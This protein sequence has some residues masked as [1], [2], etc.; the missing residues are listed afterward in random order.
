M[1]RTAYSHLLSPGRIGTLELRNR[2][3]VAAMG[4]NFGELDGASSELLVAYHE[5]QARGGVGL[6][7]SGACGVMYPVGKVQPWQI[8]ISEDRFIPGLKKVVDAVHR[9]GAKFAVQ[10]HMGGLVAGDD[11]REGRPQWC[12][13]VPEPMKGDFID[14]FLLDEL[15]SF[16]GAGVPTYKVLEH[17][18][19]QVVVKAY[20]AG[21]RRAKQA[22]CDAVEIHGGHGYLLSSFLSPKTNKR[23]DEYGGSVENRS[24]FLLEVVRAVRA[25]VGADFAVWVKLD[26]REVGKEGGITLEHATATARLVEEAGADGIAVSAYHDTGQ[27]KLHSGSNIPHEPNTN[28]PAAAAIKA[29]V[30]ISVIAAGRVEPE[31]ADAEIRAGKFDF[32]AMG[33]KLLADPQLPNKLAAGKV[34]EVR[35]CIY[36]YTCVSAIYTRERMR[37]AVNTELGIEYLRVNAPRPSVRKRVVV[38]GGGPGGMEA[39]RRLAR[40]GHEVVLLE[41]SER[42]GGTLR[43]AALAYAANERLLDWLRL[44]IET[45]DVDLRLNT[46]ATPEL[47][48]SLHPDEVVVATGARRNMPPIPGSELPH[49]FSGD[50]MRGMMLGDS[51]PALQQKTSLL[52][53][54]ATKAGA[55]TGLTA[56]LDFVRKA[57]HAWMPLGK[58]V[59]IIGGELVGL[60]LAEFLVERGRSVTIIDEAPRFGAGMTLVRRLRLLAELREHGLGLYPGS[61]DIRIATGKVAFV[62]SAGTAHSVAAEHV[63]VAKGATGDSTQADAFR[64]AG[65][66]VHEVGDGSGVGYIEGAMRGALRAVDAINAGEAVTGP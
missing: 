22:G 5:E 26:S 13:S 29:A 41:K 3:V 8:A 37:C 46:L 34:D 40:D 61:K 30:S 57:T 10:L 66:R 17:E 25:E 63:I 15:K 14:G 31:H 6:I 49:V 11:T 55:A 47:L 52:T 60:E 42:L 59:A 39:A 4:A 48:K 19:I 50:D 16:A 62:D 51:S 18:D 35:P 38:V 2:I 23:T 58:S 24:R 45:S 56:N 21:A 7:V 64:A 27:G 12:P 32:L 44:Q 43:F 20:A 1:S 33:R 28:L 65:L 53:R 36:C 54:I 9:H